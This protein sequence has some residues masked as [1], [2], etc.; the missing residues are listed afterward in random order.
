MLYE[1]D[2]GAAP[3]QRLLET[4]ALWRYR[5][6]VTLEHVRQE[7][8]EQQTAAKRRTSPFP[9]LQLFFNEVCV[10]L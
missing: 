7:L 10:A 1:V 4:P 5:S 2:V 3:T 9:V 8:A 6:R